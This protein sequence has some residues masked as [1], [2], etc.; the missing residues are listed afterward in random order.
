VE[1]VVFNRWGSV[2]FEDL[3]YKNNWGG[4]NS[5]G[6]P[7]T[8]DTYFYTLKLDGSTKTGFIIIKR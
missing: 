8:E 1:L 5:G 2:V 3:N 6:A 4:L 7:L